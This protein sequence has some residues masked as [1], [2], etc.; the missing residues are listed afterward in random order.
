MLALLSNPTREIAA[1]QAGITS[2][3]LRRYMALPAFK[4]EYLARHREMMTDAFSLAQRF[5][6]DCVAVMVSISKDAGMPAGVRVSSSGRVLDVAMKGIELEDMAERVAELQAE[7]DNL[8][9]LAQL[10]PT[11]VEQPTNGHQRRV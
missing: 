7:I 3:T 8:K 4:A 9:S 2:R 5:S 6:V 10:L 1:K 11:P